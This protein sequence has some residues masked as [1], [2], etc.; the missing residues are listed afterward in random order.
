MVFAVVM[1]PSVPLSVRHK[2]VLYRND[3]TNR[4]VFGTDASFRL[5]H[6]VLSLTGISKNYGTVFPSSGTFSQTPDL[7]N[8]ATACCIVVVWWL[9]RIHGPVLR[10]GVLRV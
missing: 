1:C 10:A 9:R 4:A 5:F 2:P 7:E 8:F 6:T 3:W